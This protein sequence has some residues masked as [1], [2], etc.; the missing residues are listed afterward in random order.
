MKK[1][2][3]R[4]YFDGEGEV[5]V[6]AENEEDARE[7]FFNGGWDNEKEWGNFYQIEEIWEIK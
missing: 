5:E 4:Y 1:Y 2:K 3:L 7:L 6:E